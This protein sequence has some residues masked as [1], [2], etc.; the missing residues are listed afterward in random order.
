MFRPWSLESI[1]LTRDQY[2]GVDMLDIV[3]VGLLGTKAGMR[4]WVA[5]LWSVSMSD[6]AAAAT[7]V[8]GGGGTENEKR[9]AGANADATKV[10]P[11]IGFAVESNGFDGA[12]VKFEVGTVVLEADEEKEKVPLGFDA[13]DSEARAATDDAVEGFENEN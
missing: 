13:E 9:V 7:G 6:V 2:M 3:V 5:L 4:D 12:V 8:A 10:A 11:V 1:S